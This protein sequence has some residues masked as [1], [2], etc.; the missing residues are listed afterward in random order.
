MSCIVYEIWVTMIGVDAKGI[1][2]TPRYPRNSC[3]SNLASSSSTMSER[4]YMNAATRTAARKKINLEPNT[5]KLKN[6]ER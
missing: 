1:R 2:A 6:L 4:I 3:S 5:F